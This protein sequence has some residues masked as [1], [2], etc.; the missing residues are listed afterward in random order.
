MGR[1]NTLTC[2]DLAEG[3]GNE[4]KSE[5]LLLGRR[6]GV[7]VGS[8]AERHG[9]VQCSSPLWSKADLFNDVEPFSPAEGTHYCLG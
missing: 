7:D 4:T 2:S 6:Q 1:R 5:N 8:L 3:V 9:V